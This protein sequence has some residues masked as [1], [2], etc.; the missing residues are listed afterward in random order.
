MICECRKAAKIAEEEG[1]TLCMEC[2]QKSFT[3]VLEGALDLMHS[4]N[5]P[6]FRMYWQ[7]STTAPALDNIKYAQ[8]IK[9]YV[10]TIHVFYYKDGKKGYL[11]DGKDDWRRYLSELSAYSGETYDN[12]RVIDH[13]KEHAEISDECEVRITRPLAADESH[14]FLRMTPMTFSVPDE[15]LETLSLSQIT[16]HMHVLKCRM[17]GAKA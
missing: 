9:D 7:P 14:A 13:L 1:V 10:D 6:A 5:S 17:K 3:N 8:G 15:V 16:I 12:A 2:H 11:K 4:V